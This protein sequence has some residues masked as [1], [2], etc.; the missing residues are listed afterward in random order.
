[1]TNDPLKN[2]RDPAH[3]KWHLWDEV[4]R[5]R[6][7][8]RLHRADRN[9]SNWRGRSLS[10][11]GGGSSWG[12]AFS[13]QSLAANVLGPAHSRRSSGVVEQLE[14]I[15]TKF[16]DKIAGDSQEDTAGQSE[17]VFFSFVFRQSGQ[18]EVTAIDFFVRY[19]S[20]VLLSRRKRSAS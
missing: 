11:R 13:Q 2:R 18:L 8:R 12:R 17:V 6:E 10:D 7:E 16:G 5:L 15:L 4:R 9:Q 20:G 3:H 14:D 19:R 1:M